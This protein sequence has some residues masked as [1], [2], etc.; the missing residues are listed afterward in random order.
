MNLVDRHLYIVLFI[1]SSL[2]IFLF[3]LTAY[4]IERFETNTL[5]TSYGILFIIFILIM[6]QRITPLI[7]LILGLIFRLIFII[8]LPELSQD[9]YRFI[10]DGNL[11]LTKINPYLYSP[12]DL[13]IKKELF[14]LANDLFKGMGSLSNMHFSNYPP[15]S[16]WLF[17][18]AAYFGENNIKNSVVFLRVIILFFEI[19]NF[20]ILYKILYFL[21]LPLKKIGWYFLN[22]LVI[23]ELTGNLHGE[24]IMMFFFLFGILLLYKNKTIQSSLM[25]AI[26]VGTKL[27]SLIL[28]PLFFK[29]LGKNKSVL[30]F[31]FFM[32]FFSFLWIPF[33]DN[34]FFENYIKT[35]TL[36]FNRFEFNGSLYY[37]IREV[38]FYT[39]GYNI[40]LEYGKITPFILIS[41][42]FFFTFIRKNNKLEK[43][44]LNQL[45]LL[46][47]YFF[48]STTVHP[49]YITSLVILC[50]FTPYF[51]PIVWS[52]TI[53]LSYSAYTLNGFQENFILILFEYLIVFA[54]FIFEFFGGEN[55][56]FRAFANN[57][58]L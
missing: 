55:K 9:F 46:S 49:W 10:W 3:S 12:N 48:I 11:Q 51:Y 7:I 21:K 24:G 40:I 29:G 25:I 37:L 41:S 42:I 4:N 34:N 23:I 43:L 8:S 18:L 53:F 54:V 35:I 31:G 2:S 47:I 38:G 58:T 32:L 50:I 39:K 57:S 14:Y 52:A 17:K 16:Q 13:I 22:P 27:I 19:C 6:F 36:W 56:I 28:I 15:I 33:L 30:Y 45:F 44:L 5:I 1:L 20:Y 26:S